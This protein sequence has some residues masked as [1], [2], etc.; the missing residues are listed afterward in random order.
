MKSGIIWPDFDAYLAFSNTKYFY[1][2]EI[3]LDQLRSV[4]D[5]INTLTNP[6]NLF[7][8]NKVYARIGCVNEL[9]TKEIILWSEE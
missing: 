8:L 1:R 4:I 9:I 3:D 5:L 7:F 6:Y 2:M